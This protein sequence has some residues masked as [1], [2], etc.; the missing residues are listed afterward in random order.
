MAVIKV[1]QFVKVVPERARAM[2]PTDLR[3]FKVLLMPWLSQVYYDD[4]NL[5]YEIAKL[6]SRYSDSRL[7]IGLHFESRDRSVNDA[8][9]TGFE[10]HLF[11]VRDALG[12]T[13]C[14]EP[15][16][17]GWSKVYTTRDYE[18]MDEEL[19]EATATQLADA[20]RV[21]QPIYRIVARR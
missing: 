1:S 17:R 2:L 10:R 5:H 7:E 15:W 20:I 9:L 18:A 16:D 12:E 11:E 4:K 6:P 14:A 8:L 19:V 21:L 3:T 13:W